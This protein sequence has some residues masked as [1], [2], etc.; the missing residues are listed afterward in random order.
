MMI[1]NRILSLLAVLALAFA[2][3]TP[4]LA[5]FDNIQ[6]KTKN[7]A[8]EKVDKSVIENK[9][10][11]DETADKTMESSGLSAAIS[12]IEV[13]CGYEGAYG[14]IATLHKL[15]LRPSATAM[16]AD[17]AAGITSVEKNYTKSP[18]QIRGIWERLDTTLFPY[19]PYYAEENRA[20]Y[21]P[22]DETP[23]IV[24]AKICRLLEEAETAFGRTGACSEFVN[25]VNGISVPA[26]DLLL[27][28]Y[29]AEF[30]ADPESYEAYNHFVRAQ[31]VHN[32]FISNQ[33]KMSVKN[34]KKYAAKTIDGTTVNLFE[35]ES[36][37]IA[38][39]NEVDR[40]AEHLALN[41]TPF[42]IICAAADNAISRYKQ[43]EANGDIKLM[44]ITNREI[45][46]IMDD[47][48]RHN[49]DDQHMSE[50]IALM[51]LYEPIK[52]TC[53]AILQFD[54][55]ASAPYVA[56]AQDESIR[57]P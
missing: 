5:Q 2:T 8:K 15:N 39:W 56:L 33:V 46:A 1:R 49:L 17:S 51:R 44:I 20:F 16:E 53:R 3:A 40:I 14:G 54:F 18:A 52:D 34:P 11:V 21:N 29:Y 24:Y 31:I 7:A 30:I 25:Y 9:L 41:V 10:D 6:N 48:A 27:C 22:D 36:D 26:I 23:I 57:K 32:G 47:L 50:Y 45:Q 55:N 35:N 12:S 4:A 19:Q 38:R 37:R 28:S 42:N 13:T 43:H